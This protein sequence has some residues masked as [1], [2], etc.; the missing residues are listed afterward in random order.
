MSRNRKPLYEGEPH[1]GTFVVWRVLGFGGRPNPLLFAR[2]SSMAMR[3]VQCL[4]NAL[5]GSAGFFRSQLYVDDPALC[6]AG[7]TSTVSLATDATLVWWLVLGLPLAWDK[8]AFYET[9]ATH[10]WIG[11]LFTLLSSGDV[12]MELPELYLRELYALLEPLSAGKGTVTLK[13]AERTV[14]K[15]GII[16]HIVPEPRPFTSGLCT[17]PSQ[18][19]P[20]QTPRALENPPPR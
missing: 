12:A 1:S 6:I 7:E 2:L 5:V 18:A 14:G 17:L 20:R 4:V 8:V 10:I 11:V 3:S 15:A 19:P 9:A 16:S 13:D